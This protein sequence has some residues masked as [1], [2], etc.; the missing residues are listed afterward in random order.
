MSKDKKNR[1]P[2]RDGFVETRLLVETLREW[3]QSLGETTRGF[4][5]CGRAAERAHVQAERSR[6]ETCG[7]IQ[8]KRKKKIPNPG[9]TKGSNDGEFIYHRYDQQKLSIPFG[10]H[11]RLA[12]R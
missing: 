8:K 4:S 3:H 11:S 5:A 12:G 9:G 6:V 7:N 10:P 1:E 2:L